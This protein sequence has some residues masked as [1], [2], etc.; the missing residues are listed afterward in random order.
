VIEL[1]S[2]TLLINLILL[3]ILSLA[4]V[5]LNFVFVCTKLDQSSIPNLIAYLVAFLPTMTI[6]IAYICPSSIYCI[7]LV[8]GLKKIVPKF[9]LNLRAYRT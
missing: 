4:Q 1:G 2:G 3:S 8:K 6:P 5:I 9:L 7:A